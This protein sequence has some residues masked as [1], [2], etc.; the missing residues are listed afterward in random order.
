MNID[1]IEKVSKSVASDFV[2]K[3]HYRKTMPKLN[4]FFYGG[5]FQNELVAIVTFGYGTQPVATIKKMFPSLGTKDYLEVGRLCLLDELPKNSESNFISRVVKELKKESEIKVLFSWSDGIMGK[6]GYV[7]Q[8]CNFEY[9]GKIKTDVYI[10]QEGY[11]IHP[12]SA[13]KVLEANAFFEHKTKMFWLSNRFCE[14][15]KI[16][17]LKGFQFRYVLFTCSRKEEKELRRS[18][19]VPIGRDYPKHKDIFF[20][21]INYA[22]GKYETADFPNYKETLSAEEVSR[23]IHVYSIDK[24]LVRFQLSAPSTL[25]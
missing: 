18:A 21:K 15:N 19:I 17:R 13:K 11:L 12:R 20:F 10:T 5:F 23:A 1:R 7:Y 2:A 24:G 14:N 9:A 22:T 4:K 3:H 8:A 25:F 16:T 6:P